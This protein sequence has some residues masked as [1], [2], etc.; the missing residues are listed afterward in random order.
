MKDYISTCSVSISAVFVFERLKKQDVLVCFITG[1]MCN[2]VASLHVSF[3][4]YNQLYQN[5]KR[6]SKDGEYFCRELMTVFQ[7]R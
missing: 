4:Q 7:Q 3:L 2:I 6:V 5:V 1:L